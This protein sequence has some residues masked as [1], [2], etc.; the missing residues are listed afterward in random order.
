MVLSGKPPE[1]RVYFVRLLSAFP[2]G[3]DGVSLT[4][5]ALAPSILFQVGVL[6][7]Q[8]TSIFEAAVTLAVYFLSRSYL[9]KSSIKLIVEVL[10]PLYGADCIFREIIL[11]SLA[12]A[13]FRMEM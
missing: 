10:K 12:Q 9:S 1:Y 13:G 7:R 2:V 8:E 6:R 5:S 11:C 4:L 3:G